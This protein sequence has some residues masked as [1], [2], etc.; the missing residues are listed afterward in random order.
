M[1][2]ERNEASVLA[3]ELE[4]RGDPRAGLVRALL[5]MASDRWGV[6]WANVE[7]ALS[8]STESMFTKLLAKGSAEAEA[9]LRE[10]LQVAMADGKIDSKER[11]MLEAAAEHLGLKGRLSEF[12]T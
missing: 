1:D 3:D 10:L 6:P 5:K 4:E 8:A 2:L 7:L 9:F 11:K 12:L